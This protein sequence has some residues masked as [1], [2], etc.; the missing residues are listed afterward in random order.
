MSFEEIDKKINEAANMHQPA[1]NEKAWDKMEQLL[2]IHLPQKEKKRRFLFL[3]LPFAVCT[4]ILIIA[5][6]DNSKKQLPGNSAVNTEKIVNKTGE[7][8]VTEQDFAE[9][10]DK[11][12]LD[13]TQKSNSE[14]EAS[15]T[16][17][18]KNKSANN[19]ETTIAQPTIF[20]KKKSL[21]PSLT[22]EKRN[23]SDR[24]NR[25]TPPLVADKTN[26]AAAVV[27]NLVSTDNKNPGVDKQITKDAKQV[28][29]T[30]NTNNKT[31]VSTKKP[32]A[33]KKQNKFA[34]RFALTLTAGPSVSMVTLNNPGKIT[35]TY[36]AG[37]N[38][39]LSKKISLST[40]I[41]V[42]KKVYSAESE[43]YHP[44]AGY[45]TYNYDLKRV[46]ADCLVFELPLFMNYTFKET[47]KHALMASAG[48]SSYIMKSEKY[49]YLYK[50][51]SGQIN[52]RGWTLKNKNEH[53]FSVVTLA[54]GYQY[55]FNNRTS[56]LIQPQ[57]KI[58]LTGIGFGKIKLNDAGTLFTLQVKPFAKK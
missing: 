33:N 18:F 51:Q 41:Y 1:F 45:W 26:T 48:I 49:D 24:N 54:G 36:G 37:L 21:L 20:K 30:S 23:N 34:D 31:E 53:Y 9:K 10:Q 4:A 16:P 5:L 55:K 47:G 8:K 58:P 50:D 32:S 38:Y 14:P 44:P 35:A 52:Y 6:H 19:F 3:L 2:D 46:D 15:A 28:D 57:I 39:A 17:E 22:S 25:Y 12:K 27:D 7:R 11:N 43:Y 13:L 56:I 29:S 42:S 40:G